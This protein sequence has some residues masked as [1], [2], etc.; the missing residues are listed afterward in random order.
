MENFI[1]NNI[2]KLPTPQLSALRGRINHYFLDYLPAYLISN[3][4]V[5]SFDSLDLDDVIIHT[6]KETE[7]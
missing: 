5:E 3:T 4:N 7:I 6:L 2:D 1:I